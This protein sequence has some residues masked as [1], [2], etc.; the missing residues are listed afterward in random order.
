MSQSVCSVGGSYLK[1]DH[2]EELQTIKL[3]RELNNVNVLTQS[4]IALFFLFAKF[5]SDHN[6]MI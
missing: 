6:A 4:I 5:S 3:T 1:I 2:H